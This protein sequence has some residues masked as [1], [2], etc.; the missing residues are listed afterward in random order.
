PAP[1]RPAGCP[2]LTW[3]RCGCPRALAAGRTWSTSWAARSAGTRWTWC[4][5]A[6][7]RR[8]PAT[9]PAPGSTRAR[10]ARPAYGQ[11]LQA[12]VAE[13]TVLRPQGATAARPGSAG[14]GGVPLLGGHRSL[15]RADPGREHRLATGKSPVQPGSQ[16]D[17]TLG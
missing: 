13:S 11:R 5:G 10:R 2:H 16:T 1:V 15:P 12:A 17:R 7:P 14:G 8:T 3:R 4:G 6:T 9:P